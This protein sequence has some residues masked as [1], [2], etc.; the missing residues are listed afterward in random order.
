MKA[1]VKKKKIND[2]F[3]VK[4][5]IPVNFQD[6]SAI[7]QGLEESLRLLSGVVFAEFRIGKSVLSIH[8]DATQILYSDI[9]EKMEN[10]GIGIPNSILFKWKKGWIKFAE[11]NMRDNA[12]AAPPVCCNKLPK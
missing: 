5:K 8:Y 1:F 11:A 2:A 9:L 4:R 3:V 12:K 10:L 7:K 6:S